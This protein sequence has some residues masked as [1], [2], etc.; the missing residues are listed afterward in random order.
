MNLYLFDRSDK[1]IHFED[2]SILNEKNKINSEAEL[3]MSENEVFVF[4]LAAVSDAD[5]V[6]K[7]IEYDGNLKIS[8]INTD[9]RDKFGKSR[10]QTVAVKKR[11]HPALVF[12]CRG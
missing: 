2:L 7:S 11:H 3:I 8:C 10:K 6:I 5:D 4:Q 1:I 12:Y 9:V